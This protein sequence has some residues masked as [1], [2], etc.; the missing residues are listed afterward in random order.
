M[1]K[2]SK[3][4]SFDQ[5]L[6]D[7][8]VVE[9][10]AERGVMSSLT[11]MIQCAAYQKIIAMGLIAV[12][13]LLAQLRSEGDDPDQWFCALNTITGHD[14]VPKD[15]TGDSVAMAKAWLQWGKTNAAELRKGISPKLPHAVWSGT[16]RILGMPLKC[17]TL[18][19]GRR[20]I[21]ATSLR[22]LYA[23]VGRGYDDVDVTDDEL[24]AFVLWQAG[25]AQLTKEEEERLEDEVDAEIARKRLEEIEHDRTLLVSGRALELRLKELL[26]E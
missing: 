9:W 13:M 1:D 25:E 19:D 11:G 21:E 10:R 26:N 23:E 17:H 12:P 22:H 15:A 20:I 5:Q 4:P 14:P 3:E 6:F 18:S 7:S 24:D 16:F 8:L 2:L